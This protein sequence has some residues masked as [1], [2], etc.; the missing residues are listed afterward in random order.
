[1]KKFN[2]NDMLDN[3]KVDPKY[4][5]QQK[6]AEAIKAIDFTVEQ[7]RAIL[8]AVLYVI[9][10]DNIITNEEKQFFLSLVADIKANVDLMKSAKDMKD[11]DM[12]KALHEINEGQ[13]GYIATCLNNAALADNDLAKEEISVVKDIMDYIPERKMPVDF[14]HKILDF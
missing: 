8:K 13:R 6:E 9:S 10:A 12:F 4:E 3:P 2:F 7:K 14:Y 11:E 1:M 5:A